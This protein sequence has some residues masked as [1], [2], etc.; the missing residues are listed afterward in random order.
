[1]SALNPERW[2]LISSHLDQVLSLSEEEHAKWLAAFRI[3]RPELADLLEKLLEEHRVLAAERFLESEPVRPATEPSVTGD[4]LGT[5]RLL[6][7]IGEG[8]MGQVWLAERVDGRFERRVAVKFLSF[9]VASRTAAE[10]FKREG[11]I[12]GQLAH[13]HIAELIDAGVTPQGEPYLVL[14]HVSGKE[15]DE[16][17][18]ERKLDIDQ[19]I[20][21]FLDVLEAIAHAHANLIVHRD[22]KPSNVLVTEA[23]EVKL[24]DFGIAKLLA[25][26]AT[27]AAATQL[28][29]KAGEG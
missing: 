24:L 14:E 7:R 22:I 15:I 20:K 8:G 13:P 2:Q 1:M 5:Y 9:A 17:C 6:N 4:T 25:D 3:Q 10:R 29:W 26:D 23:G 19:R 21:L 28:T 18:D 11:R 16:Y 12:L 27:P